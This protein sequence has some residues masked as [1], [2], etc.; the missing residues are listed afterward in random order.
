[1]VEDSINI[2]SFSCKLLVL[3]KKGRTSKNSCFGHNLHQKETS[4]GHAQNEK[5]FS[6]DRNN[7]SRSSAFRNFLFYQNIICFGGVM[8]LFLFHVM[9]FIKKGWFPAKTATEPLWRGSL[10]FTIKLPE[11]SGTHLINLEWMKRWVDLG[12][13]LL[14]FAEVWLYNFHISQ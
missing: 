7:K 2:N 14:I 3:K 6:F 4:M 10:V 8:N 1:M 12:A 11:I 5:Q 9:F 13:T